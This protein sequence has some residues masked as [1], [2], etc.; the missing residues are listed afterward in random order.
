[1][2]LFSQQKKKKKENAKMQDR[3]ASTM[4]GLV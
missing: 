3:N 1:M 2:E 4:S